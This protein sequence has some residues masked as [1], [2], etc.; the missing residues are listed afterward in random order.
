MTTTLAWA[1][2]LYL[3]MIVIGWW[4]AERDDSKERDF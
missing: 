1:F 3:A 4:V 2:G